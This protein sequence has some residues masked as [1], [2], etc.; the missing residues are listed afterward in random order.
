[1]RTD[2]E[3]LLD[4]ALR[5]VGYPAPV[6]GQLTSQDTYWSSQKEYSSNKNAVDRICRFKMCKIISSPS[7]PFPM[8]RGT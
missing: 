1:L 5:C 3:E 7:I 8:K 4:S 2:F 6:K